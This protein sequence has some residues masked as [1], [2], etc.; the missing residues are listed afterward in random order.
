MQDSRPN[1]NIWGNIITCA[2]IAIGI[3][4]I[5]GTNHKGIMMPKKMAE[6]VLP[7]NVIDMAEKDGENLCFVDDF[8]SS[9]VADEL[10]EQGI[11]T[12]PEFIARQDALKQL[13]DADIDTGFETFNEIDFELEIDKSE[14]FER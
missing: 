9:I 1:A 13:D 6:E 2:E 4:E 5:V 7:Q 12:D 11:V 8:S 10:I 14:D 3:Y